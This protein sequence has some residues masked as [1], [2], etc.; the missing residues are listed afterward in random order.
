M[1]PDGADE[2]FVETFGCHA[3]WLPTNGI[4]RPYGMY[5]SMP[6]FGLMAV[7]VPTHAA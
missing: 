5:H 7:R 6:Q 3:K 2:G 1:I 4:R